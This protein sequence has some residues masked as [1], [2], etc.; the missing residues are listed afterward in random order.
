[1]KC[2]MCNKWNFKTN[3]LRSRQRSTIFYVYVCCMSQ[4]NLKGITEKYCLTFEQGRTKPHLQ[5]IAA[6]DT[7]IPIQFGFNVTLFLRKIY[8]NIE[9]FVIK[10]FEKL[11]SLYKAKNQIFKTKS[12]LNFSKSLWAQVIIS[13]F[14]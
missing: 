13:L 8:H 4:T 12:S 11:D 1:M 14:S 10:L 6:S 5:Q 9:Q 3:I 7:F 2:V